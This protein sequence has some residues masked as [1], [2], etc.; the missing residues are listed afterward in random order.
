MTNTGRDGRTRRPALARRCV[1]AARGSPGPSPARPAFRLLLSL[2]SRHLGSSAPASRLR[3]RPPPQRGS[4]PRSCLF[5]WWGQRAAPAAAAWVAPR[6]AIEGEPRWRRLWLCEEDGRGGG[7]AEGKGTSR[8]PE[9]S[10]AGGSR[11][12]PCSGGSGS[13]SRRPSASAVGSGG[14]KR[15][16]GLPRQGQV[17][18]R[19]TWRRRP[20]EA[21]AAREAAS[22]RSWRRRE[23][24]SDRRPDFLPRRR[25]RPRSAVRPRRRPGSAGADNSAE[26]RRRGE[27]AAQGLGPERAMRAAARPRGQRRQ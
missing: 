21:A 1:Q 18:G 6:A 26:E 8:S 9:R 11:S 15:S 7:S 12:L 16:R 27:S 25:G 10:G 24:S 2:R 14:A 3:P 19:K 23:R 20:E 5:K 13:R 17:E 4:R 22:R